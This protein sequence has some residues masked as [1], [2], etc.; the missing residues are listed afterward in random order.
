MVIMK[1]K[2]Y[3]KHS[4]KIGNLQS[5]FNDYFSR[6]SNVDFEEVNISWVA[7]GNVYSKVH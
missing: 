7:I 5:T 1:K 3:P 6:V 2:N 4:D